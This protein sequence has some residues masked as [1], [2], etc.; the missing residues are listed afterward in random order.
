MSSNYVILIALADD[1]VISPERLC[2]TL[3]YAQYY[4]A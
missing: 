1:R 3:F 4:V 2:N